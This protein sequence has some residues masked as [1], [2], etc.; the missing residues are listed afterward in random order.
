MIVGFWLEKQ[1]GYG[2]DK[3][4]CLGTFRFDIPDR[5]PSGNINEKIKYWAS[6]QRRG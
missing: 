2:G 4:V 5:H 3:P 1:G 6:V